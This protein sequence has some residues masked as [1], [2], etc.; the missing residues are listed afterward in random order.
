MIVQEHILGKDYAVKKISTH[1]IDDTLAVSEFNYRNAF[2]AYAIDHITRQSPDLKAPIVHIGGA[3]H[4][5]NII[6][7]LK[8][9]R[10]EGQIKKRLYDLTPYRLLGR[11]S[12]RNYEFANNQW[13]L[14]SEVRP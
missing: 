3:A 10:T 11:Q 2:S 14:K 13:Q 6:A 8:E 9:N 7:Y 4:Q 5:K 1:G 12:I